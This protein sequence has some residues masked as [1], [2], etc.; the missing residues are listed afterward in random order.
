MVVLLNGDLIYRS[1]FRICQGTRA[2]ANAAPRRNRVFHFKG[3]HRFQ[4][5]YATTSKEMIEGNIWLA[6]S[7]PDALIFGVDFATDKQ[8]LLNTVHIVKPAVTAQFLQ[9]RGLVTKT[10]PLK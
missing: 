6:G 10:Y 2:E 7:D 8:I 5:E 1:D 9:D 4:G 3:G